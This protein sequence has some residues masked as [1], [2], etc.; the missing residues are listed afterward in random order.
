MGRLKM[1]RQE[2]D[3]KLSR[4]I[5][6]RDDLVNTCYVSRGDL[7]YGKEKYEEWDR[8]NQAFLRD[9]FE[10]GGT[11]IRHYLNYKGGMI[12]FTLDIIQAKRLNPSGSDCLPVS[13][14]ATSPPRAVSVARSASNRNVTPTEAAGG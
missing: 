5:G 6:M 13:T 9:I 14:S 4:Q 2:A 10:E 11:V 1:A 8:Y 12:L 3:L 7:Y